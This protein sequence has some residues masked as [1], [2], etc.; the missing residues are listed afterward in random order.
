MKPWLNSV[1]GATL[2]AAITAG[3]WSTALAQSKDKRKDPEQ[4]GN[5]DV[6]KGV[7]LYSLEKEIALGRELAREVEKSAK[8]VDDPLQAEY[9]NRIAQNLAR[10]SDIKVPV[11]AKWI[12]SAE[13]NAFALP[14]GFLFVNTGVM[15]KAETEAE[16]ASVMAHEIAHVAARHGTRQ[17][18]RGQIVNWA[19]LPLIFLGGWPGYAIRQGASLA[20]PL[21]FLKFSRGFENEADLLGLQYVYKAG[22]DPAAFVDFFERME[23]LEKKKPGTVSELFRSHPNVASRIKNTQKN[24]QESLKQQPLYVMTTSEFVDLKR[25]MT[26]A[27]NQRK[28][29]PE[30][31]APTLRRQPKGAPDR[32]DSDGSKSDS[33]DEAADAQAPRLVNSL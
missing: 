6:G 25:E 14:G 23:A 19:S 28:S 30:K 16:L 22:Y 7:N 5:R 31:T 3:P 4:I 18:S 29:M 2:A 26:R 8:I 1:L 13:V 27:M 20:L 10:N 24:L 21:T 32:I 12:D 17:A 11:T 15:L 9:V 33:E